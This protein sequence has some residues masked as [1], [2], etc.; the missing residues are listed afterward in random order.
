[1]TG[2]RS[3]MTGI[4][5]GMTGVRQSASGN[6][7]ACRLFLHSASFFDES[8]SRF[9]IAIEDHILHA[10]QELWFDLV[11]NLEHRRIDDSHVHSGLDRVVEEG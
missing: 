1:M 3:G 6:S 2:I 11:V 8:F 7:L 10:F 4:R 5:S 9:C